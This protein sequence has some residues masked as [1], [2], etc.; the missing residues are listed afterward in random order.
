M[1]Q[2]NRRLTRSEQRSRLVINALTL[3]VLILV[4]F[5]GK[6]L[7]SLFSAQSLQERIRSEEEELFASADIQSTEAEEPE[8]ETLVSSADTL[9]PYAGLGSIRTATEAS[10][11][12]ATEAA[13]KTE[14]TT[15]RSLATGLPAGSDAY[16]TT[17]V[18]AQAVPMDDS[19][20]N[21]A[22][23]VGDSRLE[24]FRN[25]S[26]IENGSFVTAVGMQLENFYTD[27]L[28]ATATGNIKV[29]NALAGQNYSKIYVMLGTNELGAW[30]L[31][32]VKETYTKVLS[33]IK[34]YAATPDP[35]V[36]VFSVIYVDES[37]TTAD[38]VNNQNVDAVNLKI[39]QMCQEEGY[40]YINLN[41]V[42]SDGNGSLMQGTSSDGV[43]LNAES[44]A[45]WLEYTKLHYLPTV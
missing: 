5:E 4:V 10:T 34:T 45:T 3:I 11:E 29:L 27:D 1:N 15:E 19:Y 37:L 30:D 9:S 17:V 39:L 16:M 43:H 42:L 25:F 33:D 24:G 21:D 22:V 7:I 28:I 20:F 35:I 31:D 32:H 26:G 2:K 41:E 36:Y 18:P 13:E 44:C 23:F 38:Y 14:E 12:A 6:S 8:T 40:H